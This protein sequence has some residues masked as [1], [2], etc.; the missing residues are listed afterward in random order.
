[1]AYT[2]SIEAEED[3][4]AIF[5][6]GAEQFGVVQAERY[7]DELEK[8]FDFLSTHPQAA[9]IREELTPS[10]RV[11]PFGSHIILYAV[12]ESNDLFIIRVRHTHED[13][14]NQ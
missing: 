3:V 11:H 2:L 9:R 13:W 14:I 10:V 7:H 6:S 5:L 8:I 4:I 1:M 12:T